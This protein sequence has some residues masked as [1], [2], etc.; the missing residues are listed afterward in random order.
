MSEHQNQDF[1]K[2]QRLLKLKRYEQPHPRYFN[3]LSG[4]VTARLRA[5]ATSRLDNFEEAVAQTPWLRRLWQTIEGRPALS[6]MVAAGMCGLL[7]LGG[8]LTGDPGQQP[9]LALGASEKPASE[10]KE[11]SLLAASAAT[12]VPIFSSSTNPATISAGAGSLFS[13]PLGPNLQLQSPQPVS[14]QLNP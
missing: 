5:G 7:L 9:G 1:E 12:G 10:T 3:E 4:Q 8:F 2:L 14:L 11:E 6:G 13:M